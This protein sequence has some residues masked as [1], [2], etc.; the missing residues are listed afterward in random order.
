MADATTTAGDAS[1]LPPKGDDLSAGLPA[2]SLAADGAQQNPDG[3]IQIAE[4]PAERTEIPEKHEE[5][6]KPVLQ[7]SAVSSLPTST[8]L[9]PPMAPLRAGG[10]PPA[11][12]V[13][14]APIAPLREPSSLPPLHAAP[15]S[16]PPTPTPPMNSTAAPAST[17]APTPLPKAPVPPPMPTNAPAPEVSATAPQTPVQPTAPKV[18]PPAVIPPTQLQ[19]DLAASL[20]KELAPAIAELNHKKTPTPVVQAPEGLTQKP[21]PSSPAVEIPAPKMPAPPNFRQKI[22]VPTPK[23]EIPTIETIKRSSASNEP[24]TSAPPAKADTPTSEVTE[25]AAPSAPEII[26]VEKSSLLPPIKSKEKYIPGAATGLE[27]ELASAVQQLQKTSPL[28]STGAHQTPQIFTMPKSANAAAHAST[29]PMTPPVINAMPKT[30]ST[31]A[32]SDATVAP[33]VAPLV[34]PQ[35][36][37]HVIE[38]PPIIVDEKEL[39]AITSAAPLHTAPNPVT[40]PVQNAAPQAIIPPPHEAEKIAFVPIIETAPVHDTNAPT[41]ISIPQDDALQKQGPFAGDISK[42]LKGIKLPERRDQKGAADI[43]KPAA[44]TTAA[45]T[46]AEVAK[47]IDEKVTK[48]VPVPT[49]GE[50]AAVTPEKLAADTLAEKL[51]AEVEKKRSGISTMRD[52]VVTPMRTLKVD[53]QNVITTRGMSLV[54]AVALEQDKKKDSRHLSTTEIAAHRQRS[55]HIFAILFSSAILF[56]LGG[57]ALAGVYTIE[58]Q[59]S[60][61]VSVANDASILFAE[62]TVSFPLD[63][64]TPEDIKRVLAQA[65]GGSNATL[66][67]ITRI[68]PTLST[69]TGARPVTTTELFKAMD[70]HAPDDLVRAL[71]DQFFLGI[72]TVD[73]NAPV[74]VFT[75]NSYDHAFAGML[76]WEPT[77]NADLAPFFTLVPALASGQNGLPTARPF[78]DMVMRNYDVRALRDDSGTIQLYYSFPTPTLLILAESPYSFTEILSRLQAERK[79]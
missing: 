52:S 39:Q 67:S 8:P 59:Q 9:R 78:K 48:A 35:K 74:F 77:M 19:K 71:G 36:T 55:R 57:A 31:Q 32:S 11:P 65:R 68:V 30:P 42:I 79:L 53:L 16:V 18:T 5:P 25:A 34:Q 4:T 46:E 75:V 15:A 26:R 47:I 6:L 64:Q 61:I 1:K 56:V 14:P 3:F 45:S 49:T 66:G 12:K 58:S 33:R 20:E 7:E 70:V 76:S 60:A 23:A 40:P 54:R 69:D 50:V 22:T 62:Q 28:K 10:S 72:H 51:A 29:P 24:T 41:A 63:G 73:K 44:P 38:M 17:P 43:R 2:K 13:T 21:A 27:T 37:S